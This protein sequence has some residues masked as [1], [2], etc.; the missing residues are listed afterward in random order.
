M[1]CLPSAE[2]SV[3]ESDFGRLGIVLYHH[4]VL[5][6][7]TVKG[8]NILV[9]VVPNVHYFRNLVLDS[10]A[11]LMEKMIVTDLFLH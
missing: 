2:V 8:G 3:L 5:F 11:V 6:Y 10:F 9:G 7:I 1:S 4:C